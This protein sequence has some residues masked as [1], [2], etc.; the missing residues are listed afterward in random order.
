A[1]KKEYKESTINV[2]DRFINGKV[3]QLLKQFDKYEE[4]MDLLK[5]FALINEDERSKNEN[6]INFLTNKITKIKTERFKKFYPL[7]NASYQG[8]FGDHRT[9]KYNGKGISESYHLGIDLASVRKAPVIASNDGTV[10]FVGDNG[11]YGN[12]LV[13]DH[14]LGIY[15]LYGHCSKILVNIGDEVKVGSIVARTGNTGLSLGD[16]LH[17]GML[18]QGIEVRPDEWMSSEWIN[19]NIF[20]VIK[21][22][23]KLIQGI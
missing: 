1:L 16:H 23:K 17:F 8:T 7:K 4:D 12:M 13:L 10:I 22:A 2:S 15:S 18:V 20:N 21:N 14:G 9:Y 19:R 11:I 6:N 3:T 5:K